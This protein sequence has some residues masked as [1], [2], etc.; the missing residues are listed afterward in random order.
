MDAGEHF[1]DSMRQNMRETVRIALRLLAKLTQLLQRMSGKAARQTMKITGKSVKTVA[2]K[3]KTMISQGRVSER[4]L[5]TLGDVHTQTFQQNVLQ[6][7][8]HSLYKAGIPYAIE[9]TSTDKFTLMFL[10]KDTDHVTHCVERAINRITHDQ[11]VNK[12]EKHKTNNVK[13]KKD[14]MNTIQTKYKQKMKTKHETV[15]PPV[16]TPTISKQ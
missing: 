2:H 9:N 4:H 1:Y 14:M 10:G 7:L 16:Q 5:Q 15:K 8:E 12:P 6:Q 13:T 11:P 3:S